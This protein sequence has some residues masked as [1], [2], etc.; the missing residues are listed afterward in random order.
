M[1]NT[2][3]TR[4]GQI[5]IPVEIRNALGLQEGDLFVVKQDETQIVIESQRDIVRRTAGSLAKYAREMNKGLSV[6]EIITREKAAFEQA[7]VDEY[8]ESERLQ[9]QE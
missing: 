5:T 2:K 9:E 3:M 8:L 6:D 1:A 7:I 4:K